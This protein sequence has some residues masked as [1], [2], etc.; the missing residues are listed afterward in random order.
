MHVFLS[1]WVENRQ[2][3][4]SQEKDGFSCSWANT[5]LQG[6]FL[7]VSRTMLLLWLNFLS[8][9]WSTAFS[10]S[11]VRVCPSNG[12]LLAAYFDLYKW[13]CQNVKLMCAV[14]TGF[15]GN[16]PLVIE[17]KIVKQQVNRPLI[18]KR[19]AFRALYSWVSGAWCHYPTCTLMKIESLILRDRLSQGLDGC[20]P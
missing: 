1:D 16:S 12:C 10:Y 5:L 6:P 14:R 17:K 15:G 2:F 18:H 11:W 7:E 8:V 9:I 13:N 19:K 3:E 4:L 20:H